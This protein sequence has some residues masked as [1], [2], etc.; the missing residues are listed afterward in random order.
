MYINGYFFGFAYS[1]GFQPVILCVAQPPS[2]V[3]SFAPQVNYLAPS[4]SPLACDG[5]SSLPNNQLSVLS[6]LW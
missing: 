5:V 1:T 3:T 6:G 4:S 2:A